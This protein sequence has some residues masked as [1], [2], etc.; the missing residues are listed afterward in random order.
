MQNEYPLWATQGEGCL[1]CYIIKLHFGQMTPVSVRDSSFPSSSFPLSLSRCFLPPLLISL[2][3]SFLPSFHS[4]KTY[5]VP[6]EWTSLCPREQVPSLLGLRASRSHGGK[7]LQQKRSHSYRSAR[8][9][10][11]ANERGLRSCSA[12]PHAAI[13]FLR[14]KT[15]ALP[16]YLF[17]SLSVAT[18]SVKTNSKA[19]SSVP[20]C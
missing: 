6:N 11:S 19:S 18:V 4:T 5:W 8:P 2:P 7:T 1:I 14:C 15:L 16:V 12:R 17:R 3:S 20:F 13:C 10:L 9:E